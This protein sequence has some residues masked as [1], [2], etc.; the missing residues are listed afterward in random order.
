MQL[1]EKYIKINIKEKSDSFVFLPKLCLLFDGH[2]DSSPVA[3]VKTS[4]ETNDAAQ[5]DSTLNALQKAALTRAF[6]QAGQPKVENKAVDI[7]IVKNNAKVGDLET[8]LKGYWAIIDY[9]VTDF[10]AEWAKSSEEKRIFKV[11]KTKAQFTDKD[12]EYPTIDAARYLHIWGNGDDHAHTALGVNYM[13]RAPNIGSLRP[14]Y[15]VPIEDKLLTATEKT[16]V[17]AKSINDFVR[18]PEVDSSGNES[19]SYWISRPK[20]KDG[21][22]LV[23]DYNKR[24]V[25][26]RLVA[27]MFEFFGNND[28]PYSDSNA[29]KLVNVLENVFEKLKDE[30]YITGTL[31]KTDITIKVKPIGE[32]T[33]D[34]QAKNMYVVEGTFNVPGGASGIELNYVLTQE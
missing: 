31:G 8:A 12:D 13:H 22:D 4:Y 21:S 18:R 26:D 5:K 20:L 23:R 11:L 17:L 2:S 3:F 7:I 32:T 14:L 28:F 24:V 19:Y 9:T 34:I 15:L 30:G 1:P 25:K 33:A 27:R 10:S 6:Q 16:E 29:D